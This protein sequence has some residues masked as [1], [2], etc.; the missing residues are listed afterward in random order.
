MKYAV[1]FNSKAGD[2]NILWKRDPYKLIG[3]RRTPRDLE[4]IEEEME[5]LK[6]KC[7]VAQK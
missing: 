4:V 7:S 1:G 2:K 6:S 3:L 5:K